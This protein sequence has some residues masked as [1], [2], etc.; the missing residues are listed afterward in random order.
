MKLLSFDGEAVQDDISALPPADAIAAVDLLSPTGEVLNID[1]RAGW[2]PLGDSPLK[3]SLWGVGTMFA[4]LAAT[5]VRRRPDLGA[6]RVFGLLAGSMALAL[7]VGPAAGGPAPEWA[8]VVQ[9]AA[10]LGVGA[11]FLPFAVS[12]TGCPAVRTRSRF[13]AVFS[14]VGLLLFVAFISAVLA[15]PRL[16]EV[17][18]PLAFLYVS[19]SVLGVV[20]LLIFEAVRQESLGRQQARIA[21]SGI[22]LGALPFVLFTLLPEAL[23]RESII[24]QHLTVL[25]LLLI[26]VFLAYAILRHQLLG[27]RRL[28]HRGMVYTITTLG[29]VAILAAIVALVHPLLQDIDR[30]YETIAISGLLASGILLFFPLREASRW[31]VDRFIYQQVAS[32]ESFMEVVRG[33]LVVSDGAQEVSKVIANRL[34][35]T[36]DLDSAL[37]YLGQSPEESRLVAAAGESAGQVER[38]VRPDLQRHVRSS[39]D[40]DVAEI[41]WESD[42]ILLAALRGSDGY[43]GYVLLGPKARGEVFLDE[44]KRLV[45]DIAPLLALSV[46]T[47]LL[48]QELRAL[49]QRLFK[50]EEAERARLAGDLHDGPLQKAMMLTGAFQTTLENRDLVARDLV[51]ELREIC[52][53]LRPSILDDLGIVAALEWLM[54]RVE[55]LT[56]VRAHLSICGV[57]IEDRFPPDVELVL[58]RV[59][60]EATNNSSKHSKA[61][62]V[63]VSLSMEDSALVLDIVDDGVGFTLPP[64]GS[65]GFGLSGMRERVV[66]ASGSLSINSAPGWG[67][68]TLLL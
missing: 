33:D 51:A 57:D 45:A 11:F 52:S 3:F 20:A 13:A 64:P 50:T 23:G 9:V 17:V 43:L 10:V 39:S 28:V 8:V 41:G 4:A 55:K 38:E 40:R 62:E 5:V 56:G 53:R 15:E 22:A 58:F 63:Q 19:I 54:D 2:L 1:Q 35:R 34:V 6:A 26:P 12:L 59:A 44:E 21:L 37:V 14:L 68:T 18:R 16:Y 46:D 49:T 36:L 32:F 67:A 7:A 24:P 60:Q 65:G 27:I 47:S 31:L 48:S 42:S 30:G 66:Q 25:A 61:A 29:L